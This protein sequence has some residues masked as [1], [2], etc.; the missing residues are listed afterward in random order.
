VVRTESKIVRSNAAVHVRGDA[1]AG[2]EDLDVGL[3]DVPHLAFNDG[4][5][6]P[7]HHGGADDESTNVVG[8][9]DGLK[10][11]LL[12]SVLWRER[13]QPLG[14]IGAEVLVDPVL[15]VLSLA[16]CML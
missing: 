6:H 3:G 11:R 10:L 16:A 14:S 9:L 5:N 4:G 7:L 8:P 15:A 2:D 13:L 12:C 1:Q